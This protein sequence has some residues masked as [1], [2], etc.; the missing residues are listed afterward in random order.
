M[1]RIQ[2]RVAAGSVG[3]P[4]VAIDTTRFPPRQNYSSKNGGGRERGEEEMTKRWKK[5]EMDG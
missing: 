3:R 2:I 1:R 4:V 5:Y